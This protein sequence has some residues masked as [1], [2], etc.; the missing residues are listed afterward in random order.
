MK[1]R[2]L[3]LFVV[4]A[5]LLQACKKESDFA[6]PVNLTY[7][8]EVDPN[9]VAFAVPFEKANVVLT[10]KMNNENYN[11]K[12]STEGQVSFNGIVPGTYSINVSLVVTAEEYTALT[13]IWTEEDFHL[14]YSADNLTYYNTT[15]SSV[16]LI[17]SQPLEDFVIKQIYFPGSHTTKGAN[18][19]D[20]FYE[21]YN[22]S[23]KVLYA[24]SLCFAI[25]YGKTND[26]T[27]E[28]L[29]PNLQ[30][31]WS[32]SLN[33]STLGNANTN[34]VYAKAIFMIPSN[35]RGDA[36][37]VQP[38]QSIVVAGT[39]IDHTKPYTLTSDKVQEIG[40]ATLTIDLSKADFEVYMA[41][42]LKK[43][44]P[45]NTP[46]AS[47]IDNPGVK[48]VEVI[49]ATGMNDLLMNPQGKES[50]VI[51]K[52]DGN[53]DPNNF[54]KYAA[55][56]TRTVTDATVLYPQIPTKYILDAVEASSIIEK[57]KTPRRLSLQLD[58]GKASVT[59]GP[60]SSQSI[61]R[62]TKKTVNGKRVLEDTNNSSH[63]FGFLVKA[64]PSKG[65]TSFFN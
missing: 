32:K 52:A 25:V 49:F 15:T 27:G 7:Q 44:K 16:Q 19:R 8:L 13:G 34:Y 4:I 39:A 11:A 36:Y 53:I 54:P 43:L 17:T 28:Y 33:M 29:L 48:D 46:F 5:M 1:Y 60:Y 30:F 12:V 20:Q 14:N 56:T 35:G 61:V 22:N 23:T 31:D 6:Q 58:A 42:Y 3:Q 38:G 57:D 40:D 64:D 2:F 26:N 55:P 24:D 63:D 51:F 47:D 65:S 9:I 37:P 45:N 62:K 18:F 21:I 10:N 50:Y 41:P 59:G